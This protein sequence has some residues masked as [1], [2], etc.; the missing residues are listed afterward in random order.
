[1]SRQDREIWERKHGSAG[2]N[3]SPPAAFVAENV[4]RLR[5]GRTLDLAAGSGRNS[6]FLTTLGHRVL[7]IDVARAALE[8]IRRGSPAIDLAQVDL[9]HPAFRRR[10]FDNVVCVDF[11][12]RNLFPEIRAWLR[13]G[14]ALVFDTFLIDQRLVGHPKNPD[15]LL[16]HGEL[17]QALRGYRILHYREGSVSDGGSTSFRAGA[18]AVREQN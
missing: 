4:H 11:L 1:M 12:D 2:G 18:V 7:A 16:R 8:R 9:D 13:P 14:G 17:R 5:P 6:L 10:S 15:F 3:P